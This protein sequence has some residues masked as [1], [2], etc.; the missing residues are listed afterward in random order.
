[1]RGFRLDEATAFA[2]LSE[3]NLRCQ[4]P[5]DQLSLRRKVRQAAERGYQSE[6]SMLVDRRRP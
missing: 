2:L 4:P 6:G 5:W 3:W 1:V